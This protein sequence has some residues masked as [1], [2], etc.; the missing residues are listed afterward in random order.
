MDWF[1]Y[2]NVLRHE[3]IKHLITTFAENENE[4]LRRWINVVTTF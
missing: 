1:L 3:R 4:T 2:G